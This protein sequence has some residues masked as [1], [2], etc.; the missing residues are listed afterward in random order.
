MALSAIA[1]IYLTRAAND[2][3]SLFPGHDGDSENIRIPPGV[4]TLA[5]GIFSLGC[6]I[7]MAHPTRATE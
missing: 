7:V 5:V 4:A 1:V 2:L 3:P 6:A